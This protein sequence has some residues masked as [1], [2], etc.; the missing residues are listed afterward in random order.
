MSRLLPSKSLN[1]DQS[2][3]ND[4]EAKRAGL[5]NSMRTFSL[6]TE[7]RELAMHLFQGRRS[8]KD[9][10]GQQCGSLRRLLHEAKN[11]RVGGM[12]GAD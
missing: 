5:D 10:V 6:A 7:Q 1:G 9:N 2:S 11:G 4:C 12:H 3:R 8:N